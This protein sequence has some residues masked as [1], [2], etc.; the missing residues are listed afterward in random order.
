MEEASKAM[1]EFDKESSQALES[2]ENSRTANETESLMNQTIRQL[3]KNRNESAKQKSASALENLKNIQSEMSQ[4][5]N[6]FENNTTREMA[7]KFQNTKSRKFQ[8]MVEKPIM[9]P[10]WLKTMIL[11]V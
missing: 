4:I 8:L 1:D 3:Q 10:S 2:L 11:E 6:H 7:L 5:K 9:H